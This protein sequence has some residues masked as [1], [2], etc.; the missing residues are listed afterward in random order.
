MPPKEVFHPLMH[1]HTHADRNKYTHPPDPL[2]CPL[3]PSSI[4]LLSSCRFILSSCLPALTSSFPQDSAHLRSCSTPSHLYPC[5]ALHTGKRRH[6][7]PLRTCGLSITTS[8]RSPSRC[9]HQQVRSRRK[10]THARPL[11][12]STC[13]SGWIGTAR[14][15]GEM[16]LEWGRTWC[17]RP[18]QQ[19]RR[20]YG[21]IASPV[22]R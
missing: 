18:R 17:F 20:Y 11:R 16:F 21:K 12:A 3:V 6:S 10:G 8:I 4:L 2:F 5:A 15:D 13:T 1:S 9:H 7:L 14:D 19:P 22:Y